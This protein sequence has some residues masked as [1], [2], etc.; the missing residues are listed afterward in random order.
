MAWLVARA[1]ELS[2]HPDQQVEGRSTAS[3]AIVPLEA[4]GPLARFCIS[5]WAERLAGASSWPS[6][7]SAA[8]ADDF[9]ADDE[10]EKFIESN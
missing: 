7:H 5:S 6:R 10:H 2:A 9:F 4:L 1:P 3:Q 8:T